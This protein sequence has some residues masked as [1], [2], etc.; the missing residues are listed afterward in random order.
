MQNYCDI[1]RKQYQIVPAQLQKVAEV[2]AVATAFNCNIDAVVKLSGAQ[3]SALADGF[4]LSAEDA[5]NCPT[6]LERP[7]DVV[8]GIIKCF[9]KSFTIIFC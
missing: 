5:L 1:W 6:K 3:I 2:G 7:R 4:A 8:C 9:I